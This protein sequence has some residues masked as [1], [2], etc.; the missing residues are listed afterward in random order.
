MEQPYQNQIRDLIICPITLQIF[1]EPVIASDGIT[2]EKSA[3]TKLKKSPISG[4]TFIGTPYYSYLAKNVVDNFLTAYPEYKKDQYIPVYKYT[5]YANE[6]YTFVNAGLYNKLLHFTDFDIINMSTGSN[7]C[8][9]DILTKCNDDIIKHVIDNMT[10]LNNRG[11]YGTI[12]NCVIK[13]SN[14]N[15]LKYLISKE[16]IN[17]NAKSQNGNTAIFDTFD[18]TN[19]SFSFEKFK[20]LIDNGIDIK[21]VNSNNEN[22]IHYILKFGTI[23]ILEYVQQKYVDISHLSVDIEYIVGYSNYSMLMF[24]D[25]HN[26]I[27]GGENMHMRMIQSV[28]KN[29]KFKMLKYFDENGGFGKIN[30]ARELPTILTTAFTNSSFKVIKYLVDKNIYNNKSTNIDIKNAIN[31][32]R[33]N[34]NISH[35]KKFLLAKYIKKEIETLDVVI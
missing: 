27:G 16:G 6:V 26:L 15:I 13:L 7:S 5:E 30:I 29:N 25:H 24:L 9:F 1:C 8:I 3:I 4:A 34:K 12:L 18:E 20:L 19:L 28:L 22:I 33:G 11:K 14:V 31:I 2:Y 35:T 32:L 23:E 17:I 10:N 21:I